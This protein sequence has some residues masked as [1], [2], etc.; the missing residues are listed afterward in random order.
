MQ[1]MGQDYTLYDVT[2]IHDEGQPAILIRI[3]TRNNPV[4]K[5]FRLDNTFV[6]TLWIQANIYNIKQR[7]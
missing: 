6:A 7:P 4:H 2:L 3:A 1:F 5:T